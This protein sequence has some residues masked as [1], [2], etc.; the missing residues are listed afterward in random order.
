MSSRHRKCY[1]KDC[2]SFARDK[3]GKCLNHGGGKRC[4]VQDCPRSAQGKTDKCK[5]HGGGKRCSVKDCPRSAIGKTD[6]CLNHGGG[7]RCAVKD[8]PRSARGKTDKC[9]NH[10]GGNRC[11]GVNCPDGLAGNS[12]SK[13]GDL[14]SNCDPNRN[15]KRKREECT[16]E[17]LLQ[18]KG[19]V[20]E[21]EKRIK[22]CG[23]D[24]DNKHY[25]NVDFVI[26][27][28]THRVLLSVDE[29][30]HSETKNIWGYSVLCELSRMSK[31][32]SAITETNNNRPSVWIRYNPNAYRKAGV[33]IYISKE[34]RHACLLE[35]IHKPTSKPFEVRYLFYDTDGDGLPEIF[36]HPDFNDNFK[37]LVVFQED[38]KDMKS[39]FSS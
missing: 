37:Q 21:R 22:Y 29:H 3:T 15:K 26:E 11:Q 32:M 5:A 9:A 36:N 16:I 23:V 4:A 27:T 24:E 17:E 10:G 28:Q 13:Q 34:T 2:P 35:S 20:F 33:P 39:Q 14:C 25:A 31:V 7:K 30:Q 38:Y 19:I 18:A 8:C 1:V 6:K 12:V